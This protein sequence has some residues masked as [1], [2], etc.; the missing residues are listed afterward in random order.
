MT[1]PTNAWAVFL[2]LP[3]EKTTDFDIDNNND[4]KMIGL[5]IAPSRNN[6]NLS[7]LSISQVWRRWWSKCGHERFF[8]E[9]R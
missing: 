4:N 7:V 3:D 6:A 9:K 2:R 5:P 8:S 1:Q